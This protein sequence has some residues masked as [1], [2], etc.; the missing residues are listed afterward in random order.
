MTDRSQYL[1]NLD[2]IEAAANRLRVMDGNL[3]TAEY[4]RLMETLQNYTAAILEGN[5]S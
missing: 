5:Q 4:N 1:T 3:S 2:M